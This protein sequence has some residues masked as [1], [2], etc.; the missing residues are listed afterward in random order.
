MFPDIIRGM[1]DLTAA[2]R[3]AGILPFF[4]NPVRGWSVEEHIDP[5]IWFTDRDGPWEWK[6]QLASEKICVY[7]KFVRGKAAF[8]SPEWFADLANWRR[9][10]Y[11]WSS[12]VEEG[13][14]PYKDRLLMRYL[15]DHPQVLSKYAKR[16]CGF[17]KGY[18]STVTRLQMQTYVVL[19]DFR[20]SISREGVPYGWGNAVLEPADRW[21]GPE[22]TAV[23]EDRTPEASLERLISHLARAVPGADEAALRRALR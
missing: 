19:S 1:E 13:L 21:L 15:E 8:I 14:A 11:D 7:G 10:G 2:I 18:D 22:L 20:Y 17:S 23:P 5:G 4:A 3:Q 12:R 9:E 6:G 16:E